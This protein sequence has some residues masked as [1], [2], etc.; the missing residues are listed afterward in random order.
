MSRGQR[1]ALNAPSRPPAPRVVAALLLA[2]L[3]FGAQRRAHPEEKASPSETSAATP[4][5][6]FPF[7][8]AADPFGTAALD[9]RSLN[10]RFS[11]EHGFIKTRGSSF[12]YE[13]TGRPV[14]FWAVNVGHVILE[15]DDAALDR[16]ARHLAKLGVNMVRLHGPLW[17]DGAV[18][19]L[20]QAKLSR[21]HRLVAALK[22]EGIYLA[23]SSYF[24]VWLPA[25]TVPGL[26]G[27]GGDLK[28]FSVPFFNQRFQEI[29]KGWWKAALTAKNPHTGLSL[30]EDP[31]LAF[32]EV[33]NEDGM[34]FWT[35]DPYR[36][37]PEAQMKILET[38]FGGWLQ[39]KYGGIEAAF[40]KW[41]GNGMFGSWGKKKVRGD[42]PAEGRAGFIPLWE[43]V[44][45][46]D[47][48]ARDTAEF[49]A[50]LQ[51]QY[52][53]R[54]CGYL[55]KDLGFKGSVTGSNWITADSRLLGPLDKWSNAGCDF[56]DRHGYY[57][58]VH[59]GER[60][61]YLLS[62]GDRYNDAS[63]LLFETGKPNE[64][65]FNLPLM[66]LAYNG[67]P[68]TISEI[69]WVLPNRY[70]A[71]MPVLTAAYGALQGT[72]AFFFFAS[73]AGWSDR[74][75]KFSVADPVA[76]GQFPATALIFR[77]GLVETGG[78][79]VHLEAKLADLDALKGIP[80]SAPQNV[81]DNRKGDLPASGTSGTTG[82]DGAVDPLAFLVGRVEVNVSEAGGVS[83]LPDLSKWI[84]HQ[85]KIVRSMTGQL[86][87]DYGRGFATIDAPSAQGL[88]GFL[89]KAGTLSLADLTVSSPLDYGSILVVSL[90][91]RPLKTSRKML[92]QVMSEDANSGWAAPGSGLR[93]IASVGGPPIVVKKLAGHVSLHR[94]DAASLRV[95]P[96]DFNGYPSVG[97]GPIAAGG[98]ISLLPT[99]LYYI[100]GR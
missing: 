22:R 60:A 34:F 80:L 67:K 3:P 86:T 44:N 91:G 42:L 7:D 99:T 68:S 8:V 30:V 55:K 82:T 47:A 45:K 62:N 54:M 59:E 28:T 19:E 17:R 50:G 83:S 81:D 75:A 40:A 64:L 56:M 69:N 14:R 21:V 76:M 27:Y 2:L 73:D 48:R 51:R 90:D 1:R 46:R 4:A 74:L 96:L 5:G 61:A 92:L 35:F 9:L 65:S 57:G 93:T 6:W 89:S 39:A 98:E 97:P 43:I 49:L 100:I 72:D 78:V 53:D 37:V 20:D 15:S 36:S 18:A 85:R 87:W 63:A 41:N 13:T 31:T 94:G 23:L 26:E 29:Q 38:L 88:T 58:G 12:V 32:V 33:Q 70:R 52:Y 84:D 11:G 71:D 16:F 10:E 66:D 95:T 24:P 77:Q 25:R 79:A